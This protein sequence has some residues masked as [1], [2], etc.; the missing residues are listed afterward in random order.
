MK[1]ALDILAF[2]LLGAAVVGFLWSVFQEGGAPV[3]FLLLVIPLLVAW[4]F[5]RVVGRLIG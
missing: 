1:L 3:A 2:A 4:A 5:D